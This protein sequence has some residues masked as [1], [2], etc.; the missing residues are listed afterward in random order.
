MLEKKII[1]NIQSKINLSS[2]G[3]SFFAAYLSH[4]YHCIAPYSINRAGLSVHSVV[5]FHDFLFLINL[6]SILLYIWLSLI[7][8]SEPTRPY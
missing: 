1:P 6:M 7:H 3:T 5:D 4:T 2:E 8:I